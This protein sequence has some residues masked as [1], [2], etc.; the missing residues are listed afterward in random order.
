MFTVEAPT[1]PPT[2]FTVTLVVCGP[3][4]LALP[5]TVTWKLPGAVDMLVKTVREDDPLLPEVR[6]TLDGFREVVTPTS[7]FGT[8]AVS[9]TVPSNPLLWRL[10]A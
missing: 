1:D 3:V 10:I 2:T 9:A 5:V 4:P 7:L 8:E 6:G